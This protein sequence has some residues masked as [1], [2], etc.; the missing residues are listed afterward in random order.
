MYNSGD[1]RSNH[2]IFDLIRPSFLISLLIFR[3]S[4]FSF[5]IPFCPFPAHS[6]RRL[7]PGAGTGAGGKSSRGFSPGR[8]FVSS[9]LYEIGFFFD[10]FGFSLSSGGNL[11]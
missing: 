5:F 2:A 8:D 1:F 11:C 7:P 6:V 3:K 9:F 4:S 10:E